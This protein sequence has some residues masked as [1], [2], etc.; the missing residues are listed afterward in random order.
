MGTW[1]VLARTT[2]VGK[3]QE[4]KKDM[5]T[6]LQEHS[7]SHAKLCHRGLPSMLEEND[8]R[9]HTMNIQPQVLLTDWHVTNS[10]HALSINTHTLHTPGAF[11]N[12]P[13]WP[14]L[15][16]DHGLSYQPL[17]PWSPQIVHSTVLLLAYSTINLGNRAFPSALSWRALTVRQ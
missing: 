7:I 2:L 14:G 3:G 9:L 15:S 5:G 10:C 16:T 12:G 8:R 4:G 17:L 6:G 13:I 11:C 1:V